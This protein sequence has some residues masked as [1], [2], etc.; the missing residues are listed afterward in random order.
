M[1]HIVGSQLIEELHLLFLV[2]PS[3]NALGPQ[4]LEVFRGLQGALKVIADTHKAH[5]EIPHAQRRQHLL[6]PA[7]THAHRRYHRRQ[8]GH[9]LL[10]LVDHL[11][12]IHIF[13]QIVCILGPSGRLFIGIH[14]D[15]AFADAFAHRAALLVLFGFRPG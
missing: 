5:I 12:L 13:A 15:Y 6:I 7:I 3:H 8:T 1:D 9:P 4:L 10:I 14:P 11:S 2:R